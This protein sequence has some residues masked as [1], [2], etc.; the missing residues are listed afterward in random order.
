MP[1]PRMPKI[2]AVSSTVARGHIGLSS[3]VPVLNGFGADAI[4][5]PTILLSNHPGHA[6]FAGMQ[7]PA[8]HILAMID[9][10]EANGWL[11]EIDAVLTGYFP[12]A[13]HVAAAASVISRLRAA[14]PS[15]LVCCDPVLGDHPDG[16]Y[17]SEAV[18]AAVRDQLLPLSSMITPNV[19]ELEW[20]T[21]RRVGSVLEAAG[22]AAATRTETVLVTSV[23]DGAGQVANVAAGKN[24]VWQTSSPLRENVPH[25]TG[26]AMAA[27]FLA[28]II[29]DG[30]ASA[31]LATATGFLDALV[32]ASAGHDE[33]Q[34]VA[35][36]RSAFAAP[37]ARVTRLDVATR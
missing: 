22:A 7:V 30:D 37:P 33:L 24:G 19:Y 20:L 26:D 8:A 35:A 17:V 5:I 12:S 14:L 18:A 15:V 6:R 28:T 23:P 2:L 34:L 3:V 11:R 32:D 9:A 29:Q 36:R 10:L 27:A 21:G 25:G 1:V 31:A 16:L 13:E 4:S